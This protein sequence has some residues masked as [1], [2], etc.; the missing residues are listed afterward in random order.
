VLRSD[1]SPLALASV[2]TKAIAE[3]NPRFSLSLITLDEQITNTLRLSRTLG[4]LSG[5]FG[6]LA[7]LLAA[8]GLYGIMSYTVARRRNE[9]GVR[10]ALGAAYMRIVRMVLGDTARL[11]LTGV[12]IGTVMSLGVTRLV[13]SFL[14]GVDADD[15]STLALS[16]LALAAVAFVASVIPARR[17]ARSDPVI[18]LRVD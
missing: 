10:I 5:F 14:Y 6:G 2:V 16:A 7:L 3:I 4:V 8:I 12:V 9:I 13:R 17:A 11:V 15:P 18:A 1:A